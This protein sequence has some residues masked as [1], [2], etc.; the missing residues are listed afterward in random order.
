MAGK[1]SASTG[2]L[3]TVTLTGVLAVALFVTTVIFFGRWQRANTDL[4][5]A[6]NDQRDVI[7]PGERGDDDVRL[8]IE[9]AGNQSL[10]AYLKDSLRGT[11]EEVT[12]APTTTY[13]QLQETLATV[14]GA[15]A[16]SL[17]QVVRDRTNRINAL[18]QQLADAESQLEAARADLQDEVERVARIR[19]EHTATIAALQDQLGGYESNVSEY[20]TSLN[21]TIDRNNDRVAEIR[22]TAA[23][24]EDA[25]SGQI[26][27]L[28]TEL[29]VLQDAV[30]ELRA[31]S[32]GGR[33]SAQD[34]F[35]LVDGR[36]LGSNASRNEVYVS[37]GRSDRI[38]VGMTFEVY[39]NSTAIRANDEG[40]YPPGKAAVE[41]IR[42]NEGSSTARVIRSSGQNPIVEGDV[43][44]NALYDPDKV[45]TFLVYGNFDTN[46]DGQFTQQ[47]SQGVAGLIADWGGRVVNELTGSTDFLVLGE[48]PILPPEPSPDSPLP[49]IQDYIR[50]KQAVEEYDRLF[51][52]ASQTSIPIINQ[53]RLYTLTGLTGER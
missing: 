46:R 10:V 2:M 22:R 28:E 52:I 27:E 4:E 47:E 30:R 33:V 35:A 11:M 26:A 53:N 13:E 51:R 8:L 9:Q 15:D 42:I 19:E 41:V 23:E 12:G 49:V 29:I 5:Q 21:Q 34:E 3:V 20:R 31:A 17:L 38:V 43:I 44:A 24:Q 16:A 25:M 50:K 36:V 37:L 32:A 18:Q 40:E 14:D 6:R 39:D 48:R 45:Y 1:T 7:T